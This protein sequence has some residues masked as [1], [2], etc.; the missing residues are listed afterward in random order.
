MRTHSERCSFIFLYF[1]CV[2]VIDLITQFQ[3]EDPPTHLGHVVGGT[4]VTDGHHGSDY[5]TTGTGQYHA[6]TVPSFY[7]SHG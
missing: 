2:D 4:T 5:A 7:C 1:C 6:P 3:V